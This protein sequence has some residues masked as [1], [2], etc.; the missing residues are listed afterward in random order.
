MSTYPT[1][2]QSL[3]DPNI[4]LR[5]ADL[6]AQAIA[7]SFSAL[8]GQ[9]GPFAPAP[10]PTTLVNEK[11]TVVAILAAIRDLAHMRPGDLAVVFL[12]G[13]G[14]K[15]RDD[16]DMRFL[17]RL[18]Q[19]ETGRLGYFPAHRSDFVPPPTAEPS[20]LE[21]A[22]EGLWA[23]AMGARPSAGRLASVDDEQHRV[24]DSRFDSSSVR[25]DSARAVKAPIGFSPARIRRRQGHTPCTAVCRVERRPMPWRRSSS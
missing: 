9:E 13:H 7:Q 8:T 23:S 11:A 3:H 6:D 18:P 5:E 25:T 14:L 21:S 19:D 24:L 16:A 4:N 15:T 2:A 10:R 1:L 17:I 12:A 20:K 22:R